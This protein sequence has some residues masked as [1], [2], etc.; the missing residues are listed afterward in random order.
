MGGATT[1]SAMTSTA[2]S[3]AG[4]QLGASTIAVRRSAWNTTTVRTVL[5]VAAFVVVAFGLGQHVQHM[6]A[7]PGVAD[8]S[9]AG[10]IDFRDQAYYPV[11]ALL[12]GNNPYDAARFVREYPAV[13]VFA[14]YSPVLLVLF[15]PFGLLPLG[16]AQAAYYLVTVVLVLVLARMAL[17]LGGWPAT[18]AQIFAVA[19]L[20]LCS[21]PGEWN[22]VLGQFAVLGALAI[23]AALAYGATRPTL[24][25][26]ALA[27]SLF[28]PTYGV[29]V[30]LLMLARGDRR[31]AYTGLAIAATVSLAVAAVL[32]HASGGV[33]PFV[34]ALANG[35]AAWR[36]E[37]G[38]PLHTVYRVDAA[39]LIARLLG[40]SPGIAVELAVSA[41]LLGLGALLMRRMQDAS[42]R[43]AAAGAVAGVGALVTLTGVYHL[44]YDLLLLVV[45][46]AWLIRQAMQRAESAPRT[47]FAFIGVLL[48]LPLANYAASERAASLLGPTSVW[49]HAATA[50]NAAAPLIGLLLWASM[51]LLWSRG[52]AR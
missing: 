41:L 40:H 50:V 20:I 48:A 39:A 33:G 30:A 14:P 29:P 45:P 42:S 4:A 5:C 36:A 47:V 8:D 51:V 18:T 28:K 35:V 3:V 16:A 26:I 9:H 44:L 11:R 22:A 6:L 43:G 52:A 49:W 10:L 21:R 19:T 12:E 34:S 24:A 2:N 23:C 17:R 27:V 31:A 32:A 15:L 38:D 46:V 37:S 7:V 1:R 13:K 25:G